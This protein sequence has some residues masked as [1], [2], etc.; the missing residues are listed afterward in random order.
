M[1]SATRNKKATDIFENLSFDQTKGNM[2]H[3]K[4]KGKLLHTDTLTCKFQSG[5]T[6][7]IH[8]YITKTQTVCE[9]F[10]LQEVKRV[11]RVFCFLTRNL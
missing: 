9:D 2:C 3:V 4:E 5:L 8:P 11:Q 6:E 7:M 1:L 10:I